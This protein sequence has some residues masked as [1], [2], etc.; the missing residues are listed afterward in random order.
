MRN[1]NEYKRRFN[2][3][4][5]ST[6]GDVK[7][8]IFEALEFDTFVTPEKKMLLFGGKDED[9]NDFEPRVGVIDNEFII[10]LPEASYK[11]SGYIELM[12]VYPLSTSPNWDPKSNLKIPEN[13]AIK[14]TSSEVSRKLQISNHPADHYAGSDESDMIIFYFKVPPTQKEFDNNQPYMDSFEIPCSNVRGGKIKIT[15]EIP[16]NSTIFEYEN[17]L[18]VPPPPPSI[19]ERDLSRIVRRV[20]MEQPAEEQPT[21]N[22]EEI[23]S[24][25]E[26]NKELKNSLTDLKVKKYLETDTLLQ[27]ISKYY[28]A[29]EQKSRDEK[30]EKENQKLEK[31]I[32]KLQQHLE[33]EKSGRNQEKVNKNLNRLDKTSQG[34]AFVGLDVMITNVIFAIALYLGVKFE[35]KKQGK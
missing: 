24:L 27:K 2:T 13:V 31:K 29:Q 11:A 10:T 20:I 4:L 8:L 14:G 28:K 33:D 3:L 6:M 25:E 7:P 15:V 17:P 18:S 19:S 12:L 32:K 22:K 26:L 5:E 21:V 23:K 16:K 35:N 30:L 9:N 1:I 34:I